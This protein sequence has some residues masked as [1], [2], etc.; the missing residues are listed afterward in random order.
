MPDLARKLLATV[1]NIGTHASPTWALLGYKVED[2]AIELNPEIT[3]VT[4]ITGITYTDVEKFDKQQSF[5]PNRYRE[6]NG[7]NEELLEKYRKNDVAGFSGY[8]VLQIFG[9]KGTS[10][11]YEADLYDNCT[12]TPQSIGG[13]SYVDMPLNVSFG[14][15]VTAGTVDSIQAPTTFTPT[16]T[17]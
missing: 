1:V 14:G 5:E 16:V 9:W 12:I 8:E 7:L 13:S 6:D 4:D 3:T 15:N 17:I 2:S 10:G 11:A